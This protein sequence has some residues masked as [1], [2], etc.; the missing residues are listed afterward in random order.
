[1]IDC[2]YDGFASSYSC[3]EYLAAKAIVCPTNT[4]VDAINECVAA[5]V[6][7]ESR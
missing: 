4:V 7:S 3:L 6:P 5:R 2:I 1:M